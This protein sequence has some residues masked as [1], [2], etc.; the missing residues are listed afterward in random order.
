MKHA[1]YYCVAMGAIGLA[2]LAA[3]V[4]SQATTLDI[5]G[6]YIEFDD[7]EQDL[8]ILNGTT[9]VSDS[10]LADDFQ[11]N[12]DRSGKSLTMTNAF[13][14]F[15]FKGKIGEKAYTLNGEKKQLSVAIS[16]KNGKVYLPLR[17]VMELFGTVD[18]YGDLDTVVVRY[19]FN[20]Y[21]SLPNVT[22]A[23]EPLTYERKD[24]LPEPPKEG[25]Q[26]VQQTENGLLYEKWNENNELTAVGNTDSDIIT[27]I[28][29]GYVLRHGA[30]AI[31]N[32]YLYW[33]EH[34]PTDLITVQD[35]P[36]YLYIQER[37]EDA[38]PVCVDEGSFKDL[39][40]QQFGIYLL[41]NCDF[42]NGNMIWLH[43]DKVAE[44]ITAQLYRYDSGKK[45]ILDSIPF[46]DPRYGLEVAL[47]SKDVI[48]TKLNLIGGRQQYGTM[49]R[50]DLER[51]SV[52][53]FSQGY[54]LVN[55]IVVGDYLIIRS[56]PEGNNYLPD[57]INGG[58][59]SSE[60]WVYDLEKDEWKFKVTTD[61]PMLDKYAVFNIPVV[62]DETHITLTVEGMGYAYDMPIVDLKNG[63]VY[64]AVNR[65]GTILR[66]GP[67]NFEENAVYMI[68]S[69]GS[70][71]T[72]I[73]QA[74]GKETSSREIFSVIFSD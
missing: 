68:E 61:L 43:G 18:W 56:K 38:E 71:G 54:N 13:N 17:S 52:S 70:D 44:Q 22:V 51:G 53:N 42:K 14:D 67:W 62:I 32:D 66:Y 28:H 29:E 64:T 33:V 73:M 72:N 48:W 37:K 27:P 20:D 74:Y 34:P 45:Q 57:E 65:E 26:P 9:L 36:W 7:T 1:L 3:P 47:S 4:A 21:L 31:E 39:Q 25:W 15:T 11:M 12:I 2:F 35:L 30:Y 46:G 40:E 58:N 50:M 49:K 41:D 5:N 23:E 8:T 24:N 10:F 16:E 69:K 63:I 55:P 59:I 60:L 19:D 6:S